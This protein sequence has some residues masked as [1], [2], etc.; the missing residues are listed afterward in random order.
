MGPAMYEILLDPHA[1]AA[2]AIGAL[3]EVPAGTSLGDL[4]EALTVTLFGQPLVV[5]SIAVGGVPIGR[6]TSGYLESVIHP[7]LSRR[8]SR[9][10]VDRFRC[11]T[12]GLDLYRCFYPDR[13]APTCPGDPDHGTLHGL[14]PPEPLTGLA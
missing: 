10:R 5:I 8:C 1:P 2:P 11:T 7:A 3:L 14:C 12:C 9:S 4:A 6:T 13:E